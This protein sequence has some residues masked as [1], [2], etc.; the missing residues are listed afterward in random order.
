[1]PYFAPRLRDE[2]SPPE[3]NND[4]PRQI[5]LT[6]VVDFGRLMPL[7]H[8]AVISDGATLIV[9]FFLPFCF[10]VLAGGLLAA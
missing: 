6:T 9:L 5:D 4:D 2:I 10:E 8:L 3:K 7:G 1:M